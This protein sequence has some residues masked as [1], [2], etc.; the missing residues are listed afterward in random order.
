MCD[1]FKDHDWFKKLSKKQQIKIGLLRD[2]QT[3]QGNMKEL[4]RQLDPGDTS[5]RRRKQL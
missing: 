2:A 5:D 4:V 3:K 1:D